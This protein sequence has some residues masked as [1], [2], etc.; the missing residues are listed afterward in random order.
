[1]PEGKVPINPWSKASQIIP[2]VFWTKSYDLADWVE[3]WWYR[4][5]LLHMLSP[6]TCFLPLTWHH[7]SASVLRNDPES[8]SRVEPWSPQSEER[9]EQISFMSLIHFPTTVYDS[10]ISLYNECYLH[11]SLKHRDEDKFNE[12]NLCRW[13]GDFVSIH[14]RSHRKTFWFFSVTLPR[15]TKKQL[16]YDIL[17]YIHKK[18]ALLFLSTWIK[19]SSSKQ[20]TH[21]SATSVGLTSFEMSQHLIKTIFSC[22]DIEI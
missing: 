10:H 17:Q 15:Q 8:P 4:V 1:M 7:L 20:S 11:D 16:S 9:A 21:G 22:K 13:L 18:T 19:Y 5:L 14:K 3:T 2:F 6:R 12:A